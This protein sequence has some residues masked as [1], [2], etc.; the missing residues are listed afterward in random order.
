MWISTPVPGHWTDWQY[1]DGQAHSLQLVGEGGRWLYQADG[2]NWMHSRLFDTEEEALNASELVIS[3]IETG[4]D[5]FT[6]SRQWIDPY[7]EWT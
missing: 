2:Q 4:E 6:A 5:M 7:S 1:S 3:D